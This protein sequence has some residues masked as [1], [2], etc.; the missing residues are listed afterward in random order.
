V[1]VTSWRGWATRWR[2]RRKRT[3]RNR[4]QRPTEKA[5]EREAE[6]KPCSHPGLG[7]ANVARHIIACRLTQCI[8]VQ[9]ARC[10]VAGKGC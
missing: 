4:N 7:L 6:E 3:P 9:H 10:D 2:R 5:R 1:C 8:T